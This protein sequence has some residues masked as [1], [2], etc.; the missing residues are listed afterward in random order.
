MIFLCGR[1]LYV[2]VHSVFCNINAEKLVLFHELCKR[3]VCV[4]TRLC[5]APK[6]LHFKRVP[7]RVSHEF[8]Q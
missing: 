6:I 2:G 5:S 7:N 4:I 1:V 8:Y 3:T